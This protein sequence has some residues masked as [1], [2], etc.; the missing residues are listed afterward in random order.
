M[1]I[2]DIHFKKLT[3]ANVG[4]SDA[5]L[6][7][8]N[9]SYI[10]LSTS[11]RLQHNASERMLLN[12]HIDRASNNGIP[13]GPPRVWPGGLAVSR[14]IGDSDCSHISCIPS[15]STSNFAE[16]DTIV[17]CTDGIWDVYSYNKVARL[18]TSHSIENLCKYA[19]RKPGN[20]DDVTAIIITFQKSSPPANRRFF[21]F[22]RN[23]SNAALSEE[24]SSYGNIVK[25]KSS[26][27]IV[28]S[29][30]TCDP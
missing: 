12:E 4:D 28:L 8:E 21:S 17:I 9:G 27:N 14:S 11:H 22:K 2:I 26:D 15:I 7:Y 13:Y 30:K 3:M 16:S 19:S 6:V 5:I 25:N 29:V 18:I 23:S 20:N 10:V 24:G 1:V